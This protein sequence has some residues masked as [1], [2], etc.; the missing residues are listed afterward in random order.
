MLLSNPSSPGPRP[1]C[2]SCWRQGLPGS[3][4]GTARRRPR[5]RFSP[6]CRLRSRSPRG[7]G[8]M[9]PSRLAWPML[10]LILSWGHVVVS[11]EAGIAS[12]GG[13][14]AKL[15]RDIRAVLA[16]SAPHEMVAVIVTLRDQADLRSEER[17]VGKECRY[18]WSADH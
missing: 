17:R 18:R 2:C 14:G 9:R 13:S 12:A 10:A 6:T 7:G 8:D 4:S 5:R 16:A 3:F 11:A 1:R 15:D